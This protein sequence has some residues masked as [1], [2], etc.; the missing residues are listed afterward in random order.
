MDLL[1]LTKQDLQIL[2]EKGII[3]ADTD[4]KDRKIKVVYID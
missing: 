1:I 3:F 2:T 4:L